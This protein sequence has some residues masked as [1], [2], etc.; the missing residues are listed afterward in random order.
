[1]RIIDS[2]YNIGHWHSQKFC[3]GREV[4]GGQIEK[5][6]DVILEKFSVT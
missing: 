6:C 4:E 2:Y 1:M 5:N 3:G